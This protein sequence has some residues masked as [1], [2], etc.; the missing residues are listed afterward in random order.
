MPVQFVANQL[1]IHSG[2]GFLFINALRPLYG[3]RPVQNG[4]NPP[5]LSDPPTP[6]TWT[7]TTAYTVGQTI[8]DSNNN[9]EI[10]TT[11]GTSGGTEPA[12]WA[13]AIGGTTTD[14]GVT[15]T[16]AG[17]SWI[18]KA[19]SSVSFDQQLRDSNGNIQQATIPGTTG[20]TTPTWSTL[21]GGITIDGSA[22]WQ[23]YGPTLQSGAVE[24]A[25]TFQAQGKILPVTADQYTAPI[26]A[27]LTEE[28]AK[29]SGT[30]RELQMTIVTRA[31]PNTSYVSGTDPN[32]PAGAQLFDQVTFGGLL[33]IPLPCVVILSPRP[34]Y[35]NPY[36]YIGAT[37]YKAVPESPGEIPFTLHKF[38]DYKVDWTGLSVPTR[39]AGDQI[40]QI[41]RQL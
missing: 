22:Q 2:P 33:I 1:N 16:M 9:V 6:G 13:T 25:L 29:L 36:R 40:G 8:L 37:L 12:T 17:G 30:L 10:C 7:A 20:S 3:I 31:L 11:A 21:Y 5:T 18:W 39:P 4:T 27:R 35:A 38:S 28:T 34:T 26:G 23:C 24:G 14:G 15:W 32:L 19:T 41:Y